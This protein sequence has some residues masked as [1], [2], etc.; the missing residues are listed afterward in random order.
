MVNSATLSMNV[1]LWGT[2][3]RL[4]GMT[5]NSYLLRHFNYCVAGVLLKHPL[6]KPEPEKKTELMIQQM[7]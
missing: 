1:C 7:L 2:I 3:K 6:F 4:L 5:R